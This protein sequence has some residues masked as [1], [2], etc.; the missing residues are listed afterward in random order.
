MVYKSANRKGERMRI[1][2]SH[3][4]GGKEENMKKVENIIH[5]LIK[6]NPNNFQVQS[7]QE[8]SACS[9]LKKKIN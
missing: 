4:Y 1:Y 6:E 5:S 3:P 8:M 2:I 7:T 9:I